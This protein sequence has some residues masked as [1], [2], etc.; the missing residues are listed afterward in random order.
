MF[1]A[2]LLYIS[3]KNIPHKPQRI[4]QNKLLWLTNS[5]LKLISNKR[6][7]TKDINTQTTSD[8]DSYVY[9][10]RACEREIRKKKCSYEVRISNEAK[11]NSK[12]F[13]ATLKKINKIRDNVGPLLNNVDNLLS[14]NKGMASVL[15]EAFSKVF[16]KENYRASEPMHIF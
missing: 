13:S 2:K 5:L 9:V 7:L 11:K 6:K 8:F 16:T 12:L 4:D 1:T 14:D 3:R 15:N 10:K